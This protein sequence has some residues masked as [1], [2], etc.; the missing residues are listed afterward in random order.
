MIFKLGLLIISQTYMLLFLWSLVGPPLD[1]VVMPISSVF[2]SCS[3]LQSWLVHV[4]LVQYTVEFQALCYDKMSK[5]ILILVHC[6]VVQVVLYLLGTIMY[7][8]IVCNWIV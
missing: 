6:D 4:T 8:Y 5:E 2:L 7:L 1:N 3:M